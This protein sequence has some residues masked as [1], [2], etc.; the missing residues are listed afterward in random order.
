MIL[1]KSSHHNSPEYLNFYVTFHRKSEDI[2]DKKKKKKTW[3]ILTVRL[4]ILKSRWQIDYKLF[5][6]N[7]VVFGGVNFTRVKPHLYQRNHVAV[8]DDFFLQQNVCRQNLKTPKETIFIKYFSLGQ[9]R[10]CSHYII[11]I[12]HVQC[13]RII[14]ICSMRTHS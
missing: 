11:Y 9:F 2:L 4:Q 8:I 6:N 12:L 10:Q 3:T 14:G 5:R 1:R 7:R 13:T